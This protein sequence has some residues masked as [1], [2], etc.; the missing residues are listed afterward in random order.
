V[1][2][3]THSKLEAVDIAY[4]GQATSYQCRNMDPDP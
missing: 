2:C 3:S 4:L 1:S